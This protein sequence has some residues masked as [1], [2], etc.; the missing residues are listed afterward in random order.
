MLASEALNLIPVANKMAK[1]VTPYKSKAFGMVHETF[2][3]SGAHETSYSRVNVFIPDHYGS[4][5]TVHIYSSI[6][7][8]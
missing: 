7:V 4:F 8:N 2:H 6:I 1:R 5:V 3:L